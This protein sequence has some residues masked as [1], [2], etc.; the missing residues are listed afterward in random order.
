MI[1]KNRRKL[2]VARLFTMKLLMLTS[3]WPKIFQR[4]CNSP[5]SCDTKA[6]QGTPHSCLPGLASNTPGRSSNCFC[7]WGHGDTEASHHRARSERYGGPAHLTP[8][9]SPSPPF[10]YQS[11]CR[12]ASQ[13]LRFSYFLPLRQ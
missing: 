3:P 12:P 2:E 6:A 9:P 8:S 13:H 4:H 10:G 11:S 7:C 5:G 1:F